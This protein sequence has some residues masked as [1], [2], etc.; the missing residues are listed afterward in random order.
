[1]EEVFET[2]TW[3]PLVVK[4]KITG[5]LETIKDHKFKDHLHERIEEA[6]IVEEK[7]PAD[8]ELLKEFIELKEKK[9]W[10]H[11]DTK[12]RYAELKELFKK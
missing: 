2:P 7:K 10:L 1:M 6:T 9:A 12:A 4:S 11:A 8:N 5:E 3:K